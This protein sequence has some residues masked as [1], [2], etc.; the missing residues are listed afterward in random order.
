MTMRRFRTLANSYGADLERWPEDEREPAQTLLA[1][2]EK[3]RA[4]VGSERSRDAVF[5]SL[6]RTV[7]DPADLGN[8]GAALVRLR[9]GVQSRLAAAR[10]LGERPP[11]DVQIRARQIG[12]FRLRRTVFGI[13]AGSVAVAGLLTGMLTPPIPTDAGFAILLQAAPF[14]ER[15]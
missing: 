4:L 11:G 15:D 8:D 3:A 13:L 9:T 1:A 14:P 5:A 10:P 7:S 6:A 12:A 2:S